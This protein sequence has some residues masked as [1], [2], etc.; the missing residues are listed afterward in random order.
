MTKNSDTK[1]IEASFGEQQL[2]ELEP[3][4]F[5]YND[6]LAWQIAVLC[7][8]AYLRFEEGE[9]TKLRK[10]LESGKYELVRTINGYGAQAIYVRRIDTD[11]Y[12]LV[13]RG[14][15]LKWDDISSDF[16]VILTKTPS[17]LMHY[18]FK[19]AFDSVK[20][21][22]DELLEATDS[23]KIYVAGHSLGGAL[24]IVASSSLLKKNKLAGCY[25]F[26]CPKIGESEVDWKVST[27]VYRVVNAQD[28]VP[29]LP[30]GIGAFYQHVGDLRYVTRD[31]RVLRSPGHALRIC[32]FIMALFSL[33]SLREHRIG[34]YIEKLANAALTRA[35]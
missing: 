7:R 3:I 32:Q 26:G 6:K 14:T 10:I 21:E 9:E 33:R 17:G 2:L 1:N 31:G 15:E 34:L 28:I 27:A 22:I 8:L 35:I 4:P 20:S 25:T 23:R 19:H 29:R 13:F 16:R 18:G 5:A 30:P 12:V 11:L 24:A